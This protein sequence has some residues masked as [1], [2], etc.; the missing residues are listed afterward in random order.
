M[1][2]EQITEKIEKEMREKEKMEEEALKLIEY[3]K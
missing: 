2:E 3:E 1:S